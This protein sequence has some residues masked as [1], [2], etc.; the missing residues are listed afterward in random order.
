MRI[1]LIFL[2]CCLI[3]SHSYSQEI[4]E[5][6]FKKF[7]IGISTGI[8]GLHFLEKPVAEIKLYNFSLRATYGFFYWGYGVDYEFF[9]F[10]IKLGKFT[11]KNPN[12]LI[13]SFINNKQH[14]TICF[15][16]C[17]TVRYNDVYSGTFG[18]KLYHTTHIA[19]KVT[20]GVALNS[21]KIY[22]E[23]V[24]PGYN[25]LPTKG[26]SWFPFGELSVIFNVFK[27]Y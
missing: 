7:N 19:T 26:I 22:D 5:P 17:R 20:F 14:S 27:N 10:K 8:V 3:F 1:N 16:K 13:L 12:R 18:I 11:G 4:S 15:D 9:N 6:K 25:D 21:Y 24:P 2:L 23:Y